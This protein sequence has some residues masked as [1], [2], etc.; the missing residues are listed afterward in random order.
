MGDWVGRGRALELATLVHCGARFVL[1]GALQR[2]DR[3]ALARPQAACPVERGQA[4]ARGVEI[5]IQLVDGSGGTERR[6]P[7]A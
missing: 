6:R 2:D 3:A 5:A 7:E 4:E 1:G